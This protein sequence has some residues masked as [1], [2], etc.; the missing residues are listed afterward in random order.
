MRHFVYEVSA[1]LNP[2]PGPVI[3]PLL[4]VPR[5]VEVEVG[6][7]VHEGHS[8]ILVISLGHVGDELLDLVGDVL[9]EP[10]DLLDGE[11]LARGAL[12]RHPAAH[13]GLLERAHALVKRQRQ[14]EHRLETSRGLRQ[15]DVLGLEDLAELGQQQSHPA[16]AVLVALVVE[17][18]F[19]LDHNLVEADELVLASA[20]VFLVEQ[21]R[22]G[23][24]LERAALV[25][26][27]S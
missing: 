25:S 18:D 2:I 3:I 23:A 1:M 4:V 11:V 20:L 10:R 17:L 9:H 6:G 27:S 26:S 19:S 21:V 14:L 12:G 13:C 24:D 8:R 5:V 15:L 16:L 22:V 7:R